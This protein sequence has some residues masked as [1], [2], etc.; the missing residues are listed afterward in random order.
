LEYKVD[1]FHLHWWSSLPS[2]VR[3]S[4]SVSVSSVNHSS[5]SCSTFSWPYSLT[6]RKVFE[7][8][9]HG[10]QIIRRVRYISWQLLQW[11]L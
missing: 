7:H 6:S 1:S 11:L 9:N 10:S 8:I 3:S 4:P 5:S 2:Q